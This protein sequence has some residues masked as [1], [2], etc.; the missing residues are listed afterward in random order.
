M[1]DLKKMSLDNIELSKLQGISGGG[2]QKTLGTKVLPYQDTK[3]LTFEAIPGNVTW[4]M[5][6][7]VQVP[8]GV[9]CSEPTFAPCGDE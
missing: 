3:T 9:R 8:G 5:V 7:R 4:G 6:G 2:P 1:A